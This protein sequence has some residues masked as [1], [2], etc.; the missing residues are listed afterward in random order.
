MQFSF[1]KCT[2]EEC[3]LKY[4]SLK[5]SVAWWTEGESRRNHWETELRKGT[6]YEPIGT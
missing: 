6:Q 1:S 4:R 2:R 3:G 5:H